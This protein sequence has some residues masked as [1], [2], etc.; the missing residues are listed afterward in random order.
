MILRLY[1]RLMA[2]AALPLI[3]LIWVRSKRGLEEDSHSCERKGAATIARPAGTVLWV[4]A[5]SVGEMQ[6]VMPLIKK[7]L[8]DNAA[9]TCLVTTVTVTAARLVR[10]LNNSNIIHQYAPFD[11]PRWVDAFLDHWKPDAAIWVESELWPNAL[12]AAKA[13]GI[14]MLMVNGRLSVRS[15]VRWG[16][17]RGAI[18]DIL[19]V[20]DVCLAQSD[21]DAKRLTSLGAKNVV[22][23][24]NMKYSGAPLPCDAA[25]LADLRTRIGVRPTLLFA[26]THDGEEMMALRAYQALAAK[27]PGLLVVVM[28]RHPARGDAIAATFDA[29]GATVA[30]RSQQQDIMPGTQIYL[31]DT[32]GEPGLFYRLSPVVYVGNSLISQP[33]GGHNPVEPAQLGCAI[34][35]G[36]HMWNFTEIDYDLRRTHAAMMVRTEQELW[37]AFDML[38]NDPGKTAAM[39]E[40]ARRFVGEQNGVLDKIATHLRPALSRAGIAA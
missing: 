14:P 31:A 16:K 34:V 19:N 7:L 10:R 39:G 8:A 29:Q 30:R 38:L 5:A 3:A 25:Q 32:L 24:G 36:P 37:A 12:F 6:S 13:R 4:H 23:A 11:H 22:V 20:F 35:Y 15:A 1:R 28:P 33:G 9:L 2:M 26:S 40:A 21:G 27:H 18:A 17:A